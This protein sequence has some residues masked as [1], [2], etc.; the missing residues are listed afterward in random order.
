MSEYEIRQYHPRDREGFLSLYSAVMGD[1]KH[2]RR[3]RFV[4]MEPGIVHPSTAS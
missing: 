3:D 4:M 1:E 2:S